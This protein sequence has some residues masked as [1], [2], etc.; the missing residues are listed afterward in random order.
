MSDVTDLR[1]TFGRRPKVV[2]GHPMIGRGGSEACV[3][4]AIEALK[5]DCEV[6]VVTTKKWKLHAL[7]EFYGTKIQ[8]NEV[9]VRHVPTLLPDR[10][11]AA[12]FRGAVHQRFLTRIAHE[13]DLRIGAYNPDDWGAP[14]VHLLADFSWHHE[15]RRKFDPP[16]PGFAHRG[17]LFRKMYL[18]MCRMAANPTGEDYLHDGLTLANSRWSAEQ[19]LACVGDT[20]VAVLH[21]PVWCSFPEVAWEQK[22][23]AFVMIGRIVPEKRIEKAIE[24]LAAVRAKGYALKLHLCGQL[25]SDAYGKKIKALC[26]ANRDWVIAEGP[27]TGA[28]KSELLARC[29]YGIQM[30][31]AEP[32]GI[33]VAEMVKAGALVFAPDCGGQAEIIEHNCLLFESEATAVE[34][35]DAVLRSDNLQNTLREHLAAKS[36]K[37]SAEVFMGRLR[38]L[39]VGYA[40]R[41][42]RKA[43]A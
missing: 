20:E 38:T 37:F 35:I 14:A 7:N 15:M 12:A 31:S 40:S 17:G 18:G 24:V 41:N 10:L 11:S 36:D 19:F 26:D 13:Y 43:A 6:T 5:S 23:S 25:E 32:F 16:S 22:N 1:T 28:R 9:Q 4:W 34:K 33:A 30:R 29:R 8:P 39:L 42:S 3:M 21:P 2:I 27:V